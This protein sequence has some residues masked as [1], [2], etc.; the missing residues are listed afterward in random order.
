M[1]TCLLCAIGNVDCIVSFRELIYKLD[2]RDNK[3]SN[4]NF[5]NF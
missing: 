3:I 4:I 2:E 1:S 5:I